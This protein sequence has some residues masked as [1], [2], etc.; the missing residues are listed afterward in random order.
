MN[1][2][3]KLII[4]EMIAIYCKSKHSYKDA[5]CPQCQE[6]KNYAVKRLE[7]CR[8]G[9]QKPTCRICPV[10]C[11]NPDMQAKMRE[12]MR[13]SGVR[14]LILHPLYS[15]KHFYKEFKR[16]KYEFRNSR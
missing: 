7:Q 13:Y 1:N 9:E 4:N 5:L 2:G 3:D 11:Y 12:I 8:Y 15:I 16:T 6:V 10:H 14:M